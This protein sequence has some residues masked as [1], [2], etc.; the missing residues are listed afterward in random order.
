MTKLKPKP[1]LNK[2]YVLLVVIALSALIIE[3]CKKDNHAEQQTTITD[4]AVI[5]AKSWYEST[6]PVNSNKQNTQATTTNSDL[7]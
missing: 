1:I 2:L 5:Q 7:S 4:P 6:F 3:S